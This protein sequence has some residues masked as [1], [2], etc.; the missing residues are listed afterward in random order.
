M[1]LKDL[2]EMPIAYGNMRDVADLYAEKIKG[3]LSKAPHVGDLEDFQVRF[4]APYWA[5]FSKDVFVAMMKVKDHGPSS[6]E[7][8]DVW[9][10]KDFAGKRIFSKFL[11]YLHSRENKTRIFLA[12]L[13]A[14]DTRDL[15]RAG[16]F[17]FFS[18]TWINSLTGDK[19]VFD[20]E[21][22]D[23]YYES[24]NWV[25]MLESAETMFLGLSRFFNLNEGFMRT[26]FDFNEP[27]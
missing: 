16:G 20:P 23:K 3:S 9:V 13:H 22:M 11:W 21:N 4:L 2:Y 25:L 17:R 27:F 10:N 1:K 12:D 15:L 7:I 14:Q 26:G 6:I 24:S 19:H 5:L 8:D 18:K